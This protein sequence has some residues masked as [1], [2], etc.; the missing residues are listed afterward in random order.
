MLKRL[1]IC[2]IALTV[3]LAGATVLP[4]RAYYG[5]RIDWHSARDLGFGGMS[6][7]EP[8]PSGVFGNPALLGMAD[9]PGVELSYGLGWMSEQRARTVY[10]QFENAIG[11]T[12][13]ADNLSMTGIPG[14]LAGVYPL[15]GMVGIGAGVAPA[16]DFSYR[17]YKEQRDDY[18][19]VIGEDR[20]EGTGT[21]YQAG[22]GVGVSP[23][24]WLSAGVGGG[25][26]FGNRSLESWSIRYPDTSRYAETGNPSGI[27]YAAG[28]AVQPL[29]RLALD[30][31]YRGGTG[32]S[33]WQEGTTDE[34]VS[35]SEP[36]RA[37]LGLRYTATGV[38]PSNVMAEVG[39]ESWSAVDTTFSDV[40]TVRAG[41]E[42][43]ML[44]LVRVRYGFGVEPLPF[45][46][47][48][49]VAKVGAGI[50]FDTKLAEV[51]FGVLFVRDVIGPAQFY[52]DLEPDDQTVYETGATIALSVSREF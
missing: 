14:P 16:I 51:D 21:V 38:L 37:Q 44:N 15:F 27:R 2:S 52:G 8:G 17:Y 24:D 13:V 20:V 47:T 19:N 6:R 7:P 40:F 29:S 41:V 25:Y 50:G 22:L 31:S 32:L 5:T 46:P 36:W 4:L 9:R 43:L 18:Y 1:A 28:L 33:G 45:D 3:G 49:Q 23:V 11:E 12:V 30:V 35:L 26:L 42:H 10:D 34:D 39:Y 48:V